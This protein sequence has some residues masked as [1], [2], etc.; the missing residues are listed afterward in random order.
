MMRS[1]FERR[2]PKKM[3]S[4]QPSY[5]DLAIELC[6]TL[7][8]VFKQLLRQTEGLMSSI[9]RLL[10]VEIAVPYFTTLSGRGH[11]LSL[12]AKAAPKSGEPMHLVV[13]ST[14]LKIFGEGEWLKQKHKTKRK[15]RSWPKLHLGLDLVSSQIVCSEM[16]LAILPSLLD[17]IDGRVD[18]CLADGAYDGGPTC[19]ALTERFGS[20][21]KV[22]VPPPNNAVLSPG[23]AQDPS[24]RDHHIADIA[25]HGRVAWQKASGYNQRSR[26]ETLMGRWRLSFGLKL[27][28]HVFKN[29][30]TKAKIGVRIPNPVTELDRP[31]FERTA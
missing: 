2:H 12:P 7:G 15:R 3:P 21:I 17:Q 6:L 8:I 22:A 23:A 28:A 26:S 14:G 1:V 27:K 18:L 30:K 16:T 10:T 20:A 13:D 24:I 19:A 25:A 9:A 31:N 5:S 29:P 11:R 4:G